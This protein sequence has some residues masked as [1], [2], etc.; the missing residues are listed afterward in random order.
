MIR[1]NHS[2]SIS[3]AD[4]QIDFVQAGG[5]GGQNVNKVATAAVLRFDTALLPEEI[6][7]RL[8]ALAGGRLTTEGILIIQARRY[9]TQE[10]NRQDAIQRLAELLRRAAQPPRPRHK[11]RPT[12]ASRRKRL[13]DKR[14][15]G[16]IKRQRSQPLREDG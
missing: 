2:L 16:E 13:D 3:E 14:R 15:R 6:R 8:Q 10:A 12:L 9:R 7:L 1:V 4:L 11:T 5:P